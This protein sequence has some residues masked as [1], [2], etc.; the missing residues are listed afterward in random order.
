[1][2]EV[3]FG[4]L[5]ASSRGSGDRGGTW[6]V[7]VCWQHH[8]F[9][10]A[11]PGGASLRPWTPL[12]PGKYRE[13]MDHILCVSCLILKTCAPPPPRGGGDY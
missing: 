8:P 3:T 1:M 2:L 11:S 10:S 5:E 13:Q 6:L 12:G 9:L 7:L 4:N